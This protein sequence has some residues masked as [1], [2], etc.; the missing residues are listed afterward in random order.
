MADVARETG[1]TLGTVSRALNTEGKYAIAPET[2][3]RV[4]AV[5]TRLG[6]RPNLIGRAL[7]AG[8]ATLVLLI[9][10]DPFSPYYVEISRHLSV[11]AARDGYSFVTGGAL[12]KGGASGIPA[13]DW[14]YGVDGIVVCDYLP[15]QEAHIREALRLRIPIVGLGVR[16]PFPTD[17]VKVDL[18]PASLELM[19]H[20]ADVGCR[21]PAMLSSPGAEPDDPRRRAYREAVEA[22]GFGERFV[23]VR[24]QSRAAS[25]EA[26]V[27]GYRAEAFDGLFCE[28]DLMAVGSLRGLADLGVRVPE[29]V[30]LAGCDGLEEACY[31]AV[32]ITSIV[33]PLERMCDVAWAMLQSRIEGNVE[34][35]LS[36]EFVAELQIRA[37]T[38]R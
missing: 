22:G 28:N 19:A 3:E 29:D 36:V 1:L 23:D 13:D 2:R 25:R 32:P 33:Q 12:P 34:P 11:H 10:P 24:S 31:G 16:Y 8:R 6:Y 37:S 35:T 4:L 27:R 17:F 18:Y 26:A 20:L 30:C 14:L 38:S 9:S 7:A 5:A 15:H 21:R